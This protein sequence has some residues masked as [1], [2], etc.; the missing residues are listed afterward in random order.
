[1]NVVFKK[2]GDIVNPGMY[3]VLAEDMIKFFDGVT[4][5]KVTNFED[6]CYNYVDADR[7]YWLVHKD[8]TMDVNR[9][10]DLDELF[11]MKL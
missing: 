5:R 2:I 6:D 7:T 3:P 1:M 10:E 4:I 11:S 8:W 9:H